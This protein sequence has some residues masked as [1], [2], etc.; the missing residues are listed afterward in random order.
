MATAVTS[1]V[2][3]CPFHCGLIHFERTCSILSLRMNMA[4]C[5]PKVILR[6]DAFQVNHAG[7]RSD[8]MHGPE[9][10]GAPVEEN[11]MYGNPVRIFIPTRINL[12]A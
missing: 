9:I 2:R 8:W 12:I 5:D 11:S 3:I 4:L 7:T 10:L 1:A 6:A